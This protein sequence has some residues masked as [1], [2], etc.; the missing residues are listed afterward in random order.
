MTAAESPAQAA[1]EL[2][3]EI[4]RAFKVRRLYAEGHPQRSAT[5]SSAAE[6]V[7]KILEESGVLALTLEDGGARSGDHVVPV[8][9]AETS[10][11]SILYHEGIREVAFHPGLEPPELARFLDRVA[12]VAAASAGERDL[13]A[14]LWEE[15]LPHIHYGFVER[16]ADQEWMS[17]AEG[18]AEP[19][20]GPGPGQV[21]LEPEDREALEMPVVTLPDPTTYRLTEDDL[22]RL[23]IEFEAEKARGLLHETLTCIRELL[24]DPPEDDP[25]PVVGAVADVQAGLLRE[26][27]LAD[28]R[29]LH[30]IFRPYLESPGVD[31]IVAEAFSRLSG[32]ALDEKAI[33]RLVERLEQ[34]HAEE[35]ELTG[36][37]RMFGPELL[38]EI[39][40]ALPDIKRLSQRPAIAEVLAGLAAR[41]AESLRAALERG[42]EPAAA[43]A[44]F[45]AGTLA[46]P[47][48][49]SALEAALAR[50]EPRVRLEAIQA[51]KHLGESA[52]PRAARA[53][54]DADPAVR[55][56]ALRHV[57]AHRFE[58]A[59]GTVSA[60]FDRI[61]DEAES[62]AERK[63]VYEAFG[64]L[65]GHEVVDELA[66]RMGRRG[67]FRRGDPETAACAVVGLAATGSPAARELLEE[68]TRDRDQGVREAA[69]Y[70]LSS[71]GRG[72][73]GASR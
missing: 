63:L 34:G 16:L 37:L 70:A 52:L 56:Y 64:T 27:R 61:D 39:L 21:V 7:A 40:A 42:P 3:Q 10:L 38:P 54:D 31:P 5:E 67:V 55:L 72:G 35:E 66:R 65:G 30:D 69:R 9:G 13:L 49:G 6:R 20:D 22:S 43:A 36:Y 48:L 50:P 29:A 4:V 41:N 73:T 53:V 58:P 46:D 32:A 44:A 25:T 15:T 71:W 23:Q 17:E 2:L 1:G 59:F 28:V 24:F 62:L 18:S 51:L 11:V 19:D 26:G 45:L 14:R 47:D 68:A 33:A 12:E 60:L 8:P 57:I